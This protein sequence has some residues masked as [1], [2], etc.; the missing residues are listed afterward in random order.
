MGNMKSTFKL[1][2]V[3]NIARAQQPKTGAAEAKKRKEGVSSATI[4]QR[5]SDLLRLRQKISE[6]ESSNHH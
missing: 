3:K 6:V 2:I 4:A 1:E 5:Y